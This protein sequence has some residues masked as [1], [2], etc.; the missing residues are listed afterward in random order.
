[1]DNSLPQLLLLHRWQIYKKTYRGSAGPCRTP[2][3][4]WNYLRKFLTLYI[5][6]ISINISID[7]FI[8]Q[9]RISQAFL[10]IFGSERGEGLGFTWTWINRSML[11]NSFTRGRFII[12]RI[13]TWKMWWGIYSSGCLHTMICLDAADNGTLTED[14]P[15]Q[16][17]SPGNKKKNWHKRLE[18]PYNLKV[19][20]RL[21]LL[22]FFFVNHF[23]TET[24]QF[25]MYMYVIKSIMDS[26]W[27]H[28]YN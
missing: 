9:K 4:I 23:N 1:M 5:P 25:T 3:E 28:Y 14:C 21:V 6:I 8:K 13:L 7:F 17:Y 27:Q 26:A 18:F 19:S 20:Q 12:Q 24:S 15:R 10:W 2:S 11:Q 22:H 16:S